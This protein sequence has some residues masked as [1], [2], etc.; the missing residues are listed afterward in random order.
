[1]NAVRAVIVAAALGA[2]IGLPIVPS[3]AATL[4]QAPPSAGAC[5]PSFI[6]VPGSGQ[7]AASGAEMI[8][9]QGYVDAD[10]EAAGLR[11]RADQIVNYPAV[12]WYRFTADKLRGLGVSEAAGERVLIADIGADHAKS[13]A[14]GCGQ[15]SILL[16]GYSQGAEVVIRA[17][18][19]LSADVRSTIAV[20]LLGNPSFVVPQP[21]DLDLNSK[22]RYFGVRP[23]LIRKKYTL[24]SDVLARTIDICAA[25]DPICAYHLSEIPGLIDGRSSHY[26]YTSLT[27][28]GSTLTGVAAASL[29]SHRY[30]PPTARAGSRQNMVDRLN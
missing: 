12:P 21:G 1:M 13:V 3:S 7:T 11:L 23:T 5:A 22:L 18:D 16:A 8:A 14:A 30:I 28:R 17:V 25:S 24:R 10:A 19:S 20:A 2:A 15:A 9:V 26:H 4:G 6:G 27:Y 29:W